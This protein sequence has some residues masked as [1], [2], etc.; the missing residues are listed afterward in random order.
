MPKPLYIVEG[1]I[2]HRRFLNVGGRKNLP[3]LS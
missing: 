1:Q 3:D 2:F